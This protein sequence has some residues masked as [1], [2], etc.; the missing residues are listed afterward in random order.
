M[1][2]CGVRGNNPTEVLGRQ[3]NLLSCPGGTALSHSCGSFS[4]KEFAIAK[5]HGKTAFGLCVS[6]WTEDSEQEFSCLLAVVMRGWKLGVVSTQAP[7]P[8]R[9][10]GLCLC[11][12][13]LWTQDRISWGWNAEHMKSFPFDIKQKYIMASSQ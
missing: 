9:H 11:P 12:Q 10:L 7:R 1:Q 4:G 2:L 6:L 3:T 13:H 5:Q 8:R